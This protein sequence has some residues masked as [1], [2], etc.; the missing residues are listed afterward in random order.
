MG[1]QASLEVELTFGDVLLHK[2]VQAFSVCLFA[3]LMC[4]H[5]VFEQNFI[6]PFFFLLSHLYC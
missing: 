3:H 4:V 6:F 1:N 2:L 5:I